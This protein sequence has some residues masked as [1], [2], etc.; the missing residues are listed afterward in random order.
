M[1]SEN[2]I[3]L[4]F[5]V[6]A[7]TCMLIIPEKLQ[8]GQSRVL[9]DHSNRNQVQ[10]RRRINVRRLVNMRKR[11]PSRRMPVLPAYRR[12]L[13]QPSHVR[14]A[15]PSRVNYN[16]KR[17]VQAHQYRPIRPAMANGVRRRLAAP[18]HQQPFNRPQLAKQYAHNTSAGHVLPHSFRIPIHHNAQMAPA[19]PNRHRTLSF[20]PKAF[21]RAQ[22]VSQNLR[23]A[24]Y[25]RKVKSSKRKR[26]LVLTPWFTAKGKRW[27]QYMRF[28]EIKRQMMADLLNHYESSESLN[29]MNNDT[30]EQVHKIYQNDVEQIEKTKSM[31]IEQIDN[32]YNNFVNPGRWFY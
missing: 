26:K 12:R 18:P 20:N 5:A 14:L 2:W 10:Q 11:L 30:L 6:Q 28:S 1:K 22:T 32:V 8:A 27:N 29:T 19:G 25:L 3:L 31:L 17:L 4:L 23:P 16:R 9:R 15:N 24:R 13:V 7:L 21:S